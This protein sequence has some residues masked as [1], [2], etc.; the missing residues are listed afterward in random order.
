MTMPAFRHC[1]IP[2]FQNGKN[3]VIQN[4]FYKLSFNLQ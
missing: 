1:E 4:T 3:E 2:L